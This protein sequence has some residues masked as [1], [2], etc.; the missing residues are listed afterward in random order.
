MKHTTTADEFELIR[1]I[2]ATGTV[3]RKDVNLGIGD[4]CALLTIPAD[5]QL[6]VSMDTLVAGRHFIPTAEPDALGHKALA[7]NL[8]DL[9]AMGAT[10]AWAT[11]SLTLP[12]ADT[13]WQ[14]WLKQFMAGYHAL[15][16]QYQVQLIGGDTTRGPLSITV[17]VHGFVPPGQALRRD[18]AQVGD[19]IYVSGTLGDAGLALCYQKGQYKIDETTQHTIN[20]RLNRPTPRIEL[21]Q[22]LTT[23][24]H[25]AIDISDGLGAELSHICQASGVGAIIQAQQLPIRPAVQNYIQHT[26]DWQLPVSAG[27]DYELLITAPTTAQKAV[28]QAA[29][30]ASV[31]LTRIGQIVAEPSIQM[32]M[33]DGR[34]QPLG[35]GYNHFC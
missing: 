14:T 15:A 35:N 16:H 1:N 8:S 11:L 24:A 2:I 4:D 31:P 18:A 21:G 22:A 27:D 20:E 34:A 19:H 6:A 28:Q 30:A 33:P 10:P 32:Q 13:R 5:Q 23:C 25:A 9:A 7:V 29:H 12:D 26:G 17:Q 3:Q